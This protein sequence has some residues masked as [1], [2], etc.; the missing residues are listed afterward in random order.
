MRV[1]QILQRDSDEHHII[2][3]D[4]ICESLK[5]YDIEADKRSVAADIRILSEADYGITFVNKPKKGYYFVHPDEFKPHYLGYVAVRNSEYLTDEDC[6]STFRTARL[7]VSAPS[8]RIMFDT[9]TTMDISFGLKRPN[10]VVVNTL[11]YII[12][13]NRA[14]TV[15]LRRRPNSTYT[16]DFETVDLL[17]YP[18]KIVTCRKQQ[19]LLFSLAQDDSEKLYFIS[20]W[21]VAVPEVADGSRIFSGEPDPNTAVDYFSGAHLEPMNET[22]RLT[23][24]IKEELIDSAFGFFGNNLSVRKRVDGYCACIDTLVDY[25]CIGWL[26]QNA[27]SIKILEPKALVSTLLKH[28]D[29]LSEKN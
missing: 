2:S 18:R 4:E 5:E 23:F 19:Y 25:S 9:E 26:L 12:D 22:T 17:I 8:A 20:L 11:K 16:D 7:Q 27:E 29:A 3:V 21:R 28:A 14:A 13:I 6:K 15:T 24:L 10:F 1:L